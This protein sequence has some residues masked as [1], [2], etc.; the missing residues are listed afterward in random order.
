MNIALLGEFL[1]GFGDNLVL[2]FGTI[3]TVILVAIIA[4]FSRSFAKSSHVRKNPV[5][6]LFFYGI[7]GGLLGIYGNM[8][9]YT[10][11]GAV[12][13]IRDVGPMV[14]GYCAGPLGG[15][16]AG[17]IAGVYRF[18]VGIPAGV[19]NGSTIPCSVSTV[20][21][22]VLSG[23]IYRYV[24]PKRFKDGLAFIF[25]VLFEALH[26][27][28]FTVYLGFMH[29]WPSALNSL[30]IVCL[31]YLL[32][33]GIAFFL[34]VFVNHFAHKVQKTLVNNK[35]TENELKTATN[36]QAAMLPLILPDFPGRA[37]F[38]F[39]A[40]MHPAKE[41]GGDFYDCFFVD[42]D[43]FAFLVADVS[44]KGVPAALF[45]T[46]AKIIL[47]NNITSCSSLKEAIEK[48][49]NQLLEGNQQ[50]MF[51]TSWIGVLEIST[52]KVTYV[53]AGHN[54]PVIKR[55]NKG[56]EYLKN[57]SGFIL[58]G[59]EN[60]PYKALETRLLP[61][62]KLFVYSDGV[63]EAQ[64][65][66]SELFGEDRLLDFINSRPD[67]MSA[68]EVI[69]KLKDE[70]ATFRGKAVQSDDITMVAISMTGMTAYL[71]GLPTMD[72]FEKFSNFI[73]EK[74]SE[75]NVDFKTIT[76]MQI[77]FDEIYSNIVKYSGA[78]TCT[79]G[80]SVANNEVTL[81]FTYD[82]VKFDIFNIEDPDITL[83]SSERKIGGLG[84]FI[85]KESMDKYV[86]VHDGKYNNVILKK[87]I[88]E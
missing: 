78:T 73:E 41:I 37:E 48:T 43:H 14:A 11:N 54:P 6:K 77:A 15:L 69:D 3:A 34:F 75:H 80:I 68:K 53:N 59:M 84:I 7:I 76:K 29:D 71:D 31:P 24:R 57:K 67:S 49:N 82:G 18:C 27:V 38:D 32:S 12:I 56:F 81:D 51:V 13:S 4:Q 86:Y 83:D 88:K 74:L 16:V 36:I 70:I 79:M 1:S 30:K 40:Y 47:K 55:G 2:L 23:L 66:Q 25:G 42:D 58:S 17:V 33:N 45:M 9:G 28:I 52:G 62:D 22:G 5:F 10:L 64:N 72:Q 87:K 20:L 85:V 50:H 39:A 21:I 46:V 61:D 26:L 35:A 65:E 44:G 19:L 60:M 63:T 8:A